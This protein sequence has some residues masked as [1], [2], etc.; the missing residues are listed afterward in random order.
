MEEDYEA[1]L[2]LED[3]RNMKQEY[4]RLQR[5]QMLLQQEQLNNAARAK[6]DEG[7]QE[8]LKE[9]GMNPQDFQQLMYNNPEIVLDVQKK[10]AVKYA[11]KIINK[12]A[13]KHGVVRDT[14]SG[15]YVKAQP[16]VQVSAK[17]KDGLAGIAESRREGKL[18]SDQAL[19]K[20]VGTMLQD[21]FLETMKR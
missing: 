18:N 19:E 15:K 13:K 8:V 4:E 7:I 2:A 10:S 11:S 1:K 20:M 17:S 16:G 6:I 21:F 3:A 14:K 9:A 12:A 5:G